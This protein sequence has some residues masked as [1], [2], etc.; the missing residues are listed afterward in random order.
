ME[1]ALASTSAARK[2]KAKP[3]LEK[4]SDLTRQRILDAAARILSQRGYAHTRLSDI[5][6]EADAHTGGIYYYFS[7]RESLVEEVLKIATRQTIDSVANALQALPAGASTDQILA[8]AITAQISEILA[9]DAYASA[10][11]KIY[12]Q[13]PDEIK[14]NHR[15]VLR[16]FFSRWR[17]IIRDGQARGE[18]RSDL[19]AAVI[20]LVIVGAVQWSVEWADSSTSTAEEL[21]EQ[22]AT[23]FFSGIRA[24]P[25]PG[26]TRKRAKTSP[27]AVE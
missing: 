23:I 16:E 14:E 4:K 13:V 1:D 17:Q 2:L 6:T 15:P 10:F 25:K 22:I 11:L 12:S 19:D 27:R 7:S 5:A 3:S 24:A 8:C 20:R 21:G 26:Q 9:K 18:I